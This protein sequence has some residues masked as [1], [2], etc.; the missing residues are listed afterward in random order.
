MLISIHYSLDI[1]IEILK[2]SFKAVFYLLAPTMYV[3]DIDN[4]KLEI[5]RR[6]PT[7]SGKMHKR[8]TSFSSSCSFFIKILLL[9]NRR[10]ILFL[11]QS[12]FFKK[13]NYIAAR[14]YE[15]SFSMIS[16]TTLNLKSPLHNLFFF[17]LSFMRYL[18]H[19]F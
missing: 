10:I 9:I 14:L 15:S 4:L 8:M 6:V 11:S 7:T 3:V 18:L 1:T 17:L 5:I 19:I 16:K 12:Y 2:G 13:R